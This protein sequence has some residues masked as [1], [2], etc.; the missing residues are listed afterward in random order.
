MLLYCISAVDAA[1]DITTT[2]VPKLA[3]YLRNTC[4]PKP[5]S[6]MRRQRCKSAFNTLIIFNRLGLTYICASRR[7]FLYK[8][9]DRV[10]RCGVKPATETSPR[11]WVSS[12]DLHEMSFV[13]S[14]LRRPG[15]FI[16]PAV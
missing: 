7:T 10:K 8:L 4:L 3:K 16:S 15:S 5:Q 14:Q 13:T 2:R 9:R 12:C 11:R 6:L 1:T